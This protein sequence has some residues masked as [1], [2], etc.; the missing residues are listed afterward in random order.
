MFVY[1]WLILSVFEFSVYNWWSGKFLSCIEIRYLSIM[2]NSLIF[3]VIIY[4]YYIFGV[5]YFCLFKFF[6]D[7]GL[8]LI[9]D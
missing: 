9:C 4:V 2:E 6:F 8:I 7:N 5:Y 3:I 1:K